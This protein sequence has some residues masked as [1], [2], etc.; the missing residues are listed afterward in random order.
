MKEIVCKNCDQP[1][2]PGPNLRCSNCNARFWGYDGL[3]QLPAGVRAYLDSNPGGSASDEERLDGRPVREILAGLQAD[4]R[5]IKEIE[6]LRAAGVEDFEIA[7]RLLAKTIENQQDGPDAIERPDTPGWLIVHS[8]GLEATEFVLHYG[9]NSIGA[10][11]GDT[12]PDIAIDDDLFVSREH[13]VLEVTWEETHVLFVL[14]DG[15]GNGPRQS[16]SLN[17]TFVNGRP[18]RISPTERRQIEH[19]DTIQIGRTKLALR[20]A[21]QENLDQARSRVQSAAYLKTVEIQPA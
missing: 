4:V 8:E 10:G 13:A 17:G 3:G 11:R 15:P 14:T 5:W 12:R 9:Q 19:G 2:V 20:S 16:P 21:L 7:R 18:S 1:V 6:Q